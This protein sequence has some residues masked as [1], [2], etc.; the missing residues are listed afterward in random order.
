MAHCCQKRAGGDKRPLRLEIFD[1]FSAE[2]YN[3]QDR[4]DQFSAEED[5][6]HHDLATMGKTNFQRRKVRLIWIMMV[7]VV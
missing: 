7:M 2:D 1:Q 6:N 4:K 3:H 5:Y